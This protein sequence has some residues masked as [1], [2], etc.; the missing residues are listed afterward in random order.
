MRALNKID[1]HSNVQD[2]IKQLQ[3]NNDDDEEEGNEDSSLGM[4]DVTA[5]TQRSREFVWKRRNLIIIKSR[6]WY[7]GLFYHLIINSWVFHK[8]NNPKR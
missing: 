4:L 5:W 2:L 1:Y 3:D 7:I 6:R 8:E